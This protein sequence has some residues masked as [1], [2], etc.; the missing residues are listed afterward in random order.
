M[1]DHIH[2]LYFLLATSNLV[3]TQSHFNADLQLGLPCAE[4]NMSPT[5]NKKRHQQDSNLRTQR[6]TDIKL[7]IRICRRNHLAIVPYELLRNA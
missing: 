1:E 6:V 3:N 7:S 4:K 5:A 2:V